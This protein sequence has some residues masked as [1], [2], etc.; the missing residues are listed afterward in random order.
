MP[1]TQGLA[2]VNLHVSDLKRSIRFYSEVFSLDILSEGSEVVHRGGSPVEL[3]QVILSTPGQGDLLALTQGEGLALDSGG[4]NHIG[5]VFKSDRDVLLAIDAALACGG[6]LVYQGSRE[7]EGLSEVV[8]Y[9]RDPDGYSI[10]LST[11][12]ILMSRRAMPSA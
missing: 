10:E 8:A 12:A 5:F 7:E 11:Q 6:K 2:H 3:T 1:L 9:V 4:L